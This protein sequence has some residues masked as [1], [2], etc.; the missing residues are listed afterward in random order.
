LADTGES[1]DAVAKQRHVAQVRACG[2]ARWS[3]ALATLFSTAS[4]VVAYRGLIANGTPDSEEAPGLP[5]HTA[6][7][8]A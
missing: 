4:A 8:H 6:T 1:G 5:A 2:N 3:F 7:E